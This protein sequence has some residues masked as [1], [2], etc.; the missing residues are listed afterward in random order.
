M[1]STTTISQWQSGQLANPFTRRFDGVLDVRAKKEMKKLILHSF[2]TVQKAMG[3]RHTSKIT[4]RLQEIGLDAVNNHVSG[5]CYIG[6][7]FSVY[8]LSCTNLL[9]SLCSTHCF[10]VASLIALSLEHSSRRD[11]L[12]HHQ[13]MH[14]QPRR[15]TRGQTFLGQ[16]RVETCHTIAVLLLD[17]L[18]TQ[19]RIRVSF[20][21]VGTAGTDQIVGCTLQREWVVGPVF[22]DGLCRTIGGATVGTV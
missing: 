16:R 7:T 15:T 19:Q 21:L 3:Q 10:L 1:T 11:L 20:G 13:A 2:S 18:S 9:C 14:Q 17:G 6:T 4:L 12:V 22:D 8:T 5:R